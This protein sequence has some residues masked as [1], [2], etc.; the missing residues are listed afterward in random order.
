[1]A[2]A[3]AYVIRE[4]GRH[5]SARRTGSGRKDE[6]SRETRLAPSFGRA[7]TVQGGLP[8]PVTTPGHGT[9]YDIAGRGIARTGSTEQAF[10]IACRMGS[11]G[12]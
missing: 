11:V 3:S 2:V 9:A 12:R 1:M 6:T 10:A 5:G 8:V 7:V 4:S